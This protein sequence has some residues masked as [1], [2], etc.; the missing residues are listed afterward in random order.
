MFRPILARRLPA[1]VSL[2]A[3]A[4]ALH[5][6]SALAQEEPV[7]TAQQAAEDDD[8]IVVTGTRIRTPQYDFA[9]PVVSIDS[10]TIQN[11][12]TT[13]LTSFLTDT[14]S[15]VASF[16]AN[17]ASGAEAPIGFIGLNLLNLRNLGTDRT[18]VLVDGRRH[19]SAV[20]GSSSVDVNT[21]PIDLVERVD[22]LTGG[23]SAIY[24][25]D[26][27]TGVVNFV[28]KQNFEGFKVRA[29][30]GISAQGDAANQ[31]IS[32]I[33]GHNFAGGRG[34]IAASLEYAHDDALFVGDRRRLRISPGF[35]EN[36][37]DVGDDPNL[38]DFI[39]FTDI[40]YFDSTANGA[41]DVDLDL[42][43]DFLG[44]GQPFDHGTYIGS[45]NCIQCS[46][47][48][49]STYQGEILPKI[50][51]YVAN[52]FFNFDVTDTL[53]LYAQGKYARVDASSVGQPTFDFTILTSADN[54]FLPA[55]VLDSINQVGFGAAIVN[56]DNLDIGRRG[57]NN[58]R[59]TWR[60][61]IGLKG[62]ITQDINFDISY[63]YGQS[64]ATVR[65]TNTRF[66]DRFIAAIDAVDQGQFLTGTPNG[67][68]VC[69]SNLAPIGFSDQPFYNFGGGFFFS[70]FPELS[71][72]PG[73]NS[74]CIPFNLFS[75]Q[76]APGAIDWLVTD[77]VDHSKVTQHVI[78]AAITGDFGD[79][80]RLWSDEIGFAI[81]AEY[82][83]E[84]SVSRPDPVNTTG[85]T[86]GNALFPEIGDYDVKEAF[87]E[88]RIPI[89][90]DRPFFHELSLT[91]AARYSD[92]ST[93]GSS[94]TYQVSSTWAPIRDIRFRGTYSKAVRA[95][96]IGELFSPQN[97]DFRQIEDPCRPDRLGNGTE[98]RAANCQALL[99]GLGLSPAQIAA[100]T[101]NTSAAVAGTSG[102]NPN[103]GEET[104]KTFTAGV[105]LRPRFL[106]GFSAS[107]DFYDVKI[108]DAIAIPLPQEIAELCVDQPSLDNVFC[109]A[110]TRN[111][112]T[113]LAA[114]GVIVD[115][116]R[117]P[118][119]VADFHTRG[120]DLAANYRTSLGKVGMMNFRLVGNYLDKLTLIATPGAPTSNERGLEESP[121]IQINGDVTWEYDNFQLN[122]GFN[123]FS[124]THRLS[125]D[126]RN[127]QPDF[128]PAEFMKYNERFT[129]D[130]QAAIKVNDRFTFYGGVNNMFN[131]K[132]DFG[133]FFYPVSAVGRFFYFGARVGFPGF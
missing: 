99:T 13:N 93:V 7:Q 100:F 95:P 75:E 12:G 94:F 102:G 59:E 4:A 71:F 11:A 40:R 47:T 20:P 6:S 36:P 120:I 41:I 65:Q 108:R 45:I 70:D 57:E 121:R 118:Q 24:G 5:P 42:V 79:S 114:P 83:K 64:K 111:P 97:Q 14:P 78:S 76:Q 34:N 2:F 58:R 26:A 116:T 54:P 119:N 89:A 122:Y 104:A 44:N 81:G 19:V 86:F 22:I 124:K 18:L 46:G 126:T 107:A 127:A 30:A 92:Y 73:L 9:N 115:F 88:L 62:G 96:N 85:L 28:M 33:A 77:A 90:S 10:D 101:G 66:N 1:A 110:I 130:I 91:G 129:H 131:Q 38:P 125:E 103:L 55:N 98:F 23:A 43:P 60:G 29:Q 84:K 49:V 48:P 17:D 132:P 51:R 16:D 128:Y 31:F 25:A 74:G 67:N 117:Q 105:V 56:R 63:V 27:V 39:P 112:G 8:E 35:G 53:N 50:D 109:D 69:R 37:A 82:R 32:G 3:I 21:I 68:I 106:P 133:K 123:Y 72:T 87:A 80:V 52:L 15:L 61:V 113:V